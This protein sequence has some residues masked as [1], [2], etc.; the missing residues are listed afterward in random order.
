M[1]C[2]HYCPRI[3]A[4]KNVNDSVENTD[5]WYP[6]GYDTEVDCGAIIFGLAKFWRIQEFRENGFPLKSHS[7]PFLKG[8][9]DESQFKIVVN[10][11]QHCYYQTNNFGTLK[12]LLQ[13]NC[14]FLRNIPSAA[15]AS[16]FYFQPY[17][18]YWNDIQPSMDFRIA[19]FIFLKV[20]VDSYITIYQMNHKKKVS[21]SCRAISNGPLVVIPETTSFSFFCILHQIMW[22]WVY[23]FLLSKINI[24]SGYWN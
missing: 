7:K 22:S 6:L 10:V 17:F 21:D 18:L 8:L 3:H 1:V 11:L 14:T 19:H 16:S 24:M 23:I 20:E 15:V 2:H 9:Y 4:F 12:I 5:S 13:L